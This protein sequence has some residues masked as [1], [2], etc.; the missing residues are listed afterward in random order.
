M[1]TALSSAW[2]PSLGG[3]WPLYGA[4]YKNPYLASAI[5][6]N[7]DVYTVPAGRKAIVI[8]FGFTNTSGGNVGV[9]PQLGISATYYKV[10][11]TQTISTSTYFSGNFQQIPEMVLLAGDV[12]SFNCATTAGLVIWATVVEFSASSPVTTY[13]NMAL[14]NGDNTLYTV[15]AGISAMVMRAL[16]IGEWGGAGFWYYMNSS[17]SPATLNWYNI[18]SG[19]SK[20][21]ATIT[22]VASVVTAGTT[23]RQAIA[24]VLAPGD[25]ILVNTNLNLGG[26][27]AWINV[28]ERTQPNL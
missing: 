14:A 8:N 18:P 22:T 9:Y 17:A 24:S 6:G 13:R 28:A 15:P 1:S 5:I 20:G 19:Q 11:P 4:K 27:I 25:V 12:L 7:N 23:A 2:T 21:N 16:A 10:G 26:Q 3:M